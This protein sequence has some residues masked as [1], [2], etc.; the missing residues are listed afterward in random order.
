MKD[1]GVFASA[2]LWEY[3]VGHDESIESCSILVTEANDTSRSHGGLLGQ[4][5][6]QQPGQ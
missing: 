5:V 1:G 6:G 3:W 4:Q 2:G